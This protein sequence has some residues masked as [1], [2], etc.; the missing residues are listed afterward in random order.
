LRR[1]NP[2]A[3][4]F[5]G[6]EHIDLFELVNMDGRVY[7]PRLGR[8]LS[9]DPYVQDPTYSQS[10]NRY[11]YC[12]N[13]PLVF[14]DPSGYTWLS[15]A[16]KWAKNNV[17]TIITVTYLTAA[18][19][20]AI[21]VPPLGFAMLGAYI[22][23]AMTNNWELNAEKW[24]WSSPATYGGIIIG[25]IAGYLVG[26]GL[27]HPRTVKLSLKFGFADLACVGVDIYKNDFRFTWTTNAGGR[28][29]IP[30]S[31][32]H[33]TPEELTNK[34]IN[35][36]REAAYLASQRVDEDG[37]LTFFEARFH[38][39]YGG[40]TPVFVDLNKIDLSKVSLKDFNEEGYAT[41]KLD[42]EHFSN[43]NDALVHGTIQLELVGKTNYAKIVEPGYGMYNFEM[44]PWDN[45]YNIFVRNPATIMG[46]AVNSLSV[47]PVPA[48]FPVI[49]P[50]GGTPY[51]IYYR[52][53]VR[54]K[55]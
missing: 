34:G 30:L 39:Q 16:W 32:K 1:H 40:G 38:Y 33:Q 55:P 12:V 49:I 5:T 26:Y 45:A 7:D 42:W 9:P 2:T 15:R 27:V 20:C 11:S 48:S 18:V 8:F 37:Y 25:A 29:D 53:R 41:V 46:W 13:N 17:G 14:Y 23:G 50:I 43:V 28:G 4:G 22:G 21:L 54:I 31:G 47:V 24:N 36:A 52:G 35:E 6:H 10:L 51:P 3:L 19:V 44:H